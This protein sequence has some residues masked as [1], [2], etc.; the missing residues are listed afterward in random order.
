MAAKE[1]ADKE[2]SL[3][4]AAEKIVET[5]EVGARVDGRFEIGGRDR[6]FPALIFER[7][8][9]NGYPVDSYCVLFDDG[10]YKQNFKADDL[11]ASKNRKAPPELHLQFL[12]DAKTGSRHKSHVVAV[13]SSAEDPAESLELPITDD[14]LHLGDDADL[15]GPSSLDSDD[16]GVEGG[17]FDESESG[18]FLDIPTVIPL[19]NKSR[20]NQSPSLE[21][22]GETGISPIGCPTAGTVASLPRSLSLPNLGAV[23]RSM[24]LSSLTAPS[25]ASFDVATFPSAFQNAS[26]SCRAAGL[27]LILRAL[28]LGGDGNGV[29]PRSSS[30]RDF[31]SWT[32]LKALSA[33][34]SQVSRVE[35]REGEFVKDIITCLHP[36]R[37]GERRLLKVLSPDM[38]DVGKLDIALLA[39]AEVL[40]SGAFGVVKK[41]KWK[42]Q[43]AAVKILP[44]TNKQN[45]ALGIESLYSELS[46]LERC[47]AAN[48][49]GAMTLYDFGV[50]GDQFLI[51]SELCAC[52]T[53]GSWRG[54]LTVDNDV[55][56][57]SFFLKIWSHVCRVVADIHRAG[58]IH[59]DL[60]CDNVLLRSTDF[61]SENCLCI[62]DFGEAEFRGGTKSEAAE[63]RA[64][65]T[66]R[67]QSP[68]MVTIVDRFRKEGEHFDR[69]KGENVPGELSDCWSLGCLLY[70]LI[71]GE[72]LFETGDNWA[73]FFMLLKDEKM[74]DLPEAE[75]IERLGS[76]HKIEVVV[77]LLKICLQ[78]NANRRPSAHD[79]HKN[80]KL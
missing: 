40:G 77:K 42:N 39:S 47:K 74:G 37:E 10:D 57:P 65:G 76:G 54:S 43:I 75:K 72:F 67:I 15:V 36:M 73:K 28:T 5:F 18:V 21:N 63:V 58:I 62:C 51:V 68:E 29:Y 13:V 55:H 35:E 4:A 9:E 22:I 48:I 71:V 32:P 56:T 23:G 19:S 69:R 33:V 3:K 38:F 16:S 61:D 79:L 46:A 53:L 80:S 30:Q 14:L 6:W 66:E 11:R 52:G 1:A 70:E 34:L 50:S 20:F 7:E 45:A 8:Y 27:A 78:R 26:S 2:S 12:D 41:C 49:T 17:L 44:R 31:D 60:K 64:R 25:P 59:H 24:S